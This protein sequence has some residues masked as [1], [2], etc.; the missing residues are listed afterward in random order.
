LCL[1]FYAV[2]LEQ[3]IKQQYRIKWFGCPEAKGSLAKLVEGEVSGYHFFRNLT[4]V[5]GKDF[6][7][8]LA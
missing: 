3:V 6:M 5:Q 2:L 4:A 7:Y 1:S 8:L